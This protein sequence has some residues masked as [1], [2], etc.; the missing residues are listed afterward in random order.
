MISGQWP[1]IRISCFISAAVLGLFDFL[2]CRGQI[3]SPGAPFRRYPCYQVSLG[4]YP[5]SIG[6]QTGEWLQV[7]LG[8]GLRCRDLRG[9]DYTE[10][11]QLSFNPIAVASAGHGAW[12][13]TGQRTFNLTTSISP[14]MPSAAAIRRER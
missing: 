12:Q 9:L 4:K 8:I 7:F 10:A 2:C 13:M 5:F 6:L 14:S 1:E 3:A 11:D